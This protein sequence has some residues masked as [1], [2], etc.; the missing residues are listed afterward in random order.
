M[1]IMPSYEG[2]YNQI[3]TRLPIVSGANNAASRQHSGRSTCQ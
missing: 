1:S 3:Y 2:Y